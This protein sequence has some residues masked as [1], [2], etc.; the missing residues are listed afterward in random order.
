MSN[1]IC[2]SGKVGDSTFVVFKDGIRTSGEVKVG[3][4]HFHYMDEDAGKVRAS[5]SKK[6][7]EIDF[8]R[9]YW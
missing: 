7:D 2:K 8:K 5:I 1:S 4:V 6:I 3:N 9:K